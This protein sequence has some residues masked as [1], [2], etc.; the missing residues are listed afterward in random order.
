MFFSPVILLLC[1]FQPVF[2]CLGGCNSSQPA[3]GA[4]EALEDMTGSDLFPP[5]IILAAPLLPDGSIS[6]GYWQGFAIYFKQ[7]AWTCVVA[8]SGCWEAAKGRCFPRSFWESVCLMNGSCYLRRSVG[9]HLA[10]NLYSCPQW[11]FSY[12]KALFMMSSYPHFVMVMLWQW[13]FTVLPDKSLRTNRLGIFCI[14]TGLICNIK[15]LIIIINEPAVVG[16]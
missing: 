1:I 16:L 7:N 15:H 14:P 10:I 5:S 4:M 3:R 11:W 9:L 6:K 12:F 13:E 8:T 2:G